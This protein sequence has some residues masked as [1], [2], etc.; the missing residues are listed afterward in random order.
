MIEMS[1]RAFLLSRPGLTEHVGERFTPSPLPLGSELPALCYL[2]IDDLP[3]M[4]SGGPSCYVETR[5]Q[6]ESWAS[7]LQAARALD[8]LVVGVLFGYRGSWPGGIRVGGAFI[9]GSWALAD[10]ESGLWRAITDY[11][12]KY[13]EPRRET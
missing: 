4:D 9:R 2:I 1:L 13:F 5:I 12:I 3:T 10:P 8:R 6:I 11:S 7:S